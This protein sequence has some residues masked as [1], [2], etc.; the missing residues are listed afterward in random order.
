MFIINDEMKGLEEGAKIFSI[1]HSINAPRISAVDRPAE[2]TR[3]FICSTEEG[4]KFL[5]HV[6]LYLTE[7]QARV[8]YTWDAGPVATNKRGGVEEEALDFVESMGFMMDN[9]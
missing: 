7:S 2:V 5:T 3:A 9:L 4:S 1:L 8:V 6:I